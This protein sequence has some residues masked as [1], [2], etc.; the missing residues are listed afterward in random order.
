MIGPYKN[1][2]FVKLMYDAEA[3]APKMQA[4]PEFQAIMADI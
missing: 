3:L 4:E 1:A 2:G